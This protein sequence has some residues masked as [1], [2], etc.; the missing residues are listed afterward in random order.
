MM[1]A[2]R[3]EVGM[4]LRGQREGFGEPVAVLTVVVVIPVYR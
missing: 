2:L 3:R 1:W 4:V